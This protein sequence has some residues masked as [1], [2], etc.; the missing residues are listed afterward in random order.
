MSQIFISAFIC[1]NAVILMFL[2][3]FNLFDI[4]N[5][6][7]AAQFKYMI[8][9]IGQFSDISQRPITITSTLKTHK[10]NAFDD[11]VLISSHEVITII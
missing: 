2:Y 11:L 4:C 10:F 1:I 8:I 7:V 9:R 5:A 3:W 6:T